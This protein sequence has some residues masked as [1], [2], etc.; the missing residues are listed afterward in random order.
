MRTVTPSAGLILNLVDIQSSSV[1]IATKKH[2][3][4]VSVHFKNFRLLLIC[5]FC[6]F[7]WLNKFAATVRLRACRRYGPRRRRSASRHVRRGG[8]SPRQSSP[9]PRQGDAP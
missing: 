1:L 2:I 7:L 4:E 8:P 3:E 5:A 6:A 9:L